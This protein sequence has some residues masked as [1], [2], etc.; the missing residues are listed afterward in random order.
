MGINQVNSLNYKRLEKRAEVEKFLNRLKRIT[1]VDIA[2]LNIEENQQIL[3][4]LVEKL[5]KDTINISIVSEVSNG[6]STF[7]N[8]LVFDEPVLESKIGETTA[9]VFNIKYGEKFSINGRVCQ[10]LDALKEQISLENSKNLQAVNEKREPYNIQSEITLPNENLKNGIELYDT[11]GFTTNNEKPM[12]NL[13]KNAVS[14]SDATILLLDIAQ[15]IKNSEA[16][17]IKNILH[18]IPLN[19]RFIVLNKYD[20]IFDE[21]DLILKSKEEIEEEIENLVEEMKKILYTL[22]KERSQTIETFTLSSK[23]ALVGKITKNQQKLDE[24]RFLIFEELFW[25]RVVEAKDELFEDRVQLFENIQNET[26]KHLLK[27]RTIFLNQIEILEIK[28]E[29]IEKREHI[30]N[31]IEAQLEQLKSLDRELTKEYRERIAKY[32]KTFLEDSQK[33]LT[34]NLEGE[35]SNISLLD[36]VLIF[37]LRKCY[38]ESIVTVFNNSISYLENTLEQFIHHTLN[39]PLQDKKRE[40]INNINSELNINFRM[41]K[42]D[43]KHKIDET[44]TRILYRVKAYNNWDYSILINILKQNIKSQKPLS[45]PFPIDDLTTEISYRREEIL[46]ILENSGNE[47]MD[48]FTLVDTTLEELNRTIE[49][50]E[51]YY[52]TIEQ[53]THS[54]EEIDSF[55]ESVMDA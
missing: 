43:K 44:I 21:D 28:L 1:T 37:P 15:G 47:L 3:E 51:E 26:E 42:Y 36:R 53:L 39:E 19:K 22:Q 10:D 4:G 40:I 14:N 35:L 30:L 16:L 29:Q 25:Q 18:Q 12:L 49:F 7:L 9:K 31:I 23:K 6:K 38:K 33:M 27:E 50:K 17:F 8:A 45:F 32:E 52:Q 13:I 46:R 20:T 48:Y 41:K 24:S 55:V 34:L 2:D 11:P 5:G 54:V